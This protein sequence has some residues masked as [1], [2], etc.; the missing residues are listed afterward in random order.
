M[1][2]AW[3]PKWTSYLGDNSEGVL[4]E[5]LNGTTVFEERDLWSALDVSIEKEDFP[6]SI[7]RFRQHAFEVRGERV[8]KVLLE[9]KA[10]HRAILEEQEKVLKFKRDDF[11]A[12][13]D[14]FIERTPDEEL[15][16]LFEHKGVA[17]IFR[18]AAPHSGLWLLF[19]KGYWAETRI[20]KRRGW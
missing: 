11:K 9:R 19:L 6:P 15:N 12:S 3:G 20:S 7:A 1:N 14:D 2:N 17:K 5:W 10:K 16:E 4:K 13:F 18:N 8:H